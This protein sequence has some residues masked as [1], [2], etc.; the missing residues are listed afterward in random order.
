[1]VFF[2]AFVQVAE[3]EAVA[4]ESTKDEEEEEFLLD[5]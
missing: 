3:E 1:M 4:K 2:L 5:Y